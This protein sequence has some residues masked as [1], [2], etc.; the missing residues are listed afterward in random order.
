M[1]IYRSIN[2]ELDL[3]V[4]VPVHRQMVVNVAQGTEARDTLRHHASPSLS[5]ASV[6]MQAA[7]VQ[8]RPGGEELRDRN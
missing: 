8:G 7:S 6:T 3:Y 5:H 2:L 1:R 4:P